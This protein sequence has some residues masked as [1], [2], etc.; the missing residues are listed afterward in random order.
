MSA[1]SVSAGRPIS[2]PLTPD[3]AAL[4]ALDRTRFFLVHSSD[5][6]PRVLGAATLLPAAMTCLSASDEGPAPLSMHQEDRLV[7]MTQQS[8][9]LAAE[10]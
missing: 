1:G 2:C 5:D 7:R 4:W 9:S 10:Q 3:H 8:L 6:P